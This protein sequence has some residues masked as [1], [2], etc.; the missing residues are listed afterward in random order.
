MRIH[1]N[2]F[3]PDLSEKVHFPNL[4]DFKEQFW[5]KNFA[6]RASMA[7][8]LFLVNADCLQ[9]AFDYVIDYSAEHLPGLIMSD[10]QIQELRRDYREAHPEIDYVDNEW[11][12]MG[13]VDEY[14]SGG[15]AGQYLSTYN[16]V[17]EEF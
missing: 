7:G 8:T 14:I 6:I 13:F 11:A 10:G 3:G 15:N 12:D 5:A 2:W 9:D 1:T 16:V 4:D 17:F